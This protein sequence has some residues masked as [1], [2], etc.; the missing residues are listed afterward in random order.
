MAEV[1]ESSSCLEVVSRVPVKDVRVFGAFIDQVDSVGSGNCQKIGKP[2]SSS[3]VLPC[4][5]LVFWFWVDAF[6]RKESGY[7]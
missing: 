7:P 4:M 1:R 5:T 6:R 2:Y 3:C